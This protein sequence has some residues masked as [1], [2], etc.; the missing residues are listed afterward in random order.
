MLTREIFFILFFA[1]HANIYV[2][3]LSFPVIGGFNNSRT[4]VRNGRKILRDSRTANVLSES[5]PVQIRI[6]TSKSELNR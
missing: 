4:V 1:A 3:H 2:R 6:E 5:Q